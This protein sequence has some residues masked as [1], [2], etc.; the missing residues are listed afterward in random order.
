M[1]DHRDA[2]Q[3]RPGSGS[4]PESRATPDVKDPL[5]LIDDCLAQMPDDDPRQKILYKLRHLV[6]QQGA[7]AQQREAEFKKLTEV[8]SKLTAPANRIGTLLEIPAEGLARIMVGGAE[9]YTNIDPRVAAGDLK[10]GTQVLV[11]EAYA[12]IKTLGYDPNG[13]VLKISAQS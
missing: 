13:P 11:N 5:V 1:S 7:G 12:V 9:Y 6:L 2:D 3:R 10:I 4:K 8:V